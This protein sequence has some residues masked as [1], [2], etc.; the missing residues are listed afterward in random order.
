[1]LEDWP[2]SFRERLMTLLTVVIT[3]SELAQRLNDLGTMT[4]ECVELW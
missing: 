1:M 3:F 4:Q 2:E